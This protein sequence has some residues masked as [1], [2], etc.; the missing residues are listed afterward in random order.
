[1]ATQQPHIL[2]L[3]GGGIAVVSPWNAALV[4]ECKRR[5]GA[6][7][8]ITTPSGA[9]QGWKLDA[10]HRPDMERLLA[11]LFPPRESLVER[12]ITF[13]SSG[14]SYSPTVDGYDLIGFSR[15]RSWVKRFDGGEP[16]QI[17]HVMES[18]LET[19]GSRNNPRLY[20]RCVIKLR[21]RPQAQVL[22]NG[23]SVEIVGD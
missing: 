18:N 21:C 19:G 14:S 5:M 6:F 15:D 3:Q 13:Q 22:W 9:V 16:L 4:E 8:T 2:N 12:I 17:L 20:G 10:I 11:E 7:K 1:M 23:G